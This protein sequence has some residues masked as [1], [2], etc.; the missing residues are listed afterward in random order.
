MG[1]LH[2]KGYSGSVDYS[3]DDRCFGGKV[4]GLHRDCILYEGD[5]VDSL[6]KD[7]QESI[8]FYLESC[9]ERN[10]EPEKPFSG[11]LIIRISPEEHGSAAE[12]AADKGISLNEFIRRAIVAAL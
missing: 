8:D 4:L 12:K 2:Y 3:E 9:R 1:H 7:F 10:V 11:K 5:T 6:T